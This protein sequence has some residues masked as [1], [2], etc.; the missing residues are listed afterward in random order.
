LRRDNVACWEYVVVENRIEQPIIHF[1]GSIPLPDAETVF[2]REREWTDRA[3]RFVK[4]ELKRADVTYE[5]LARRLRE[6]GLDETKYSVA[7]K[8]GRGTFP[9][10]LFF[11]AMK[12]IGREQ[13]N[14]GDI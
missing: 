3:R 1:V 11:A 2:R 7:A 6:H 9:T 8:I 4:V 13:V 14:L 10:A 5:E 12:A